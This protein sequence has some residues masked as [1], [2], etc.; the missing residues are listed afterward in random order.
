MNN[1]QILAAAL[2][3][4]SDQ[5]NS[6]DLIVGNIVIQVTK[7]IVNLQSEQQKIIVHYVG[8]NGK[9]WKPSKSMGRALA[10]IL[11]GD[12]S[13]WEGQEIELFRNKEISFGKDKCGGIQIAAMGALKNAITIMITTKRGVKSK[14]TIQPLKPSVIEQPKQQTQKVITP[15]RE[16]A[17]KIKA[18]INYGSEAV[19]EIWEKVPEEFK[20]EMQAFYDEKLGESQAF[21]PVSELPPV[22]EEP[23]AHNGEQSDMAD[24]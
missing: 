18:A 9:P 7:V 8:D 15:Q 1:E 23:P 19:N 21:D 13:N 17:T 11:G 12:F 2:A 16:W 4:R 20:P 10:E 6:D 22:S 24:F 14:F 3:P 5:L